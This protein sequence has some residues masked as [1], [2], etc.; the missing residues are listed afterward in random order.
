MICGTQLNAPDS[1]ILKRSSA[2]PSRQAGY[3]QLVRELG[4]HGDERR[5]LSDHCASWFRQDSW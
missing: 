1:V 3:K 5:L 2:S 4:L